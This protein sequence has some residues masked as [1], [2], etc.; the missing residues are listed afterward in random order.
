ML[1]PVLAEPGKGM[2]GRLFA[3]RPDAPPQLK[4]GH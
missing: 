2:L 1:W 4:P 3:T